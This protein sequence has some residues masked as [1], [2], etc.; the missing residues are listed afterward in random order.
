MVNCIPSD[1][2][3]YF[4]IRLKFTQLIRDVLLISWNYMTTL[5]ILI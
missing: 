5:I 3:M 2:E 1:C 4:Q